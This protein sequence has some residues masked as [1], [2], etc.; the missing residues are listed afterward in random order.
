MDLAGRMGVDSL[1]GG[2][3]AGGSVGRTE[4]RV[5]GPAISKRELIYMLLSKGGRNWQRLFLCEHFVFS[6][7]QEKMQSEPLG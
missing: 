2:V 6:H 4:I 7:N 3:S 1:R 5:G